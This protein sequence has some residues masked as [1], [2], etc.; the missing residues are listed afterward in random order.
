[1]AA[2]VTAKLALDTRGFNAGLKRAR[3]S[4]NSIGKAGAAAGLVAVAAGFTAVAI[5]MKK[6]IDLGGQLSDLADQTGVAAGDLYLL[7]TA[8][9][10]NGIEASKAAQKL[11]KMQK[12]IVEGKQGLSTYVRAF[13][14]MG[15]SI[16]S[17]DGRDAMEQFKEIGAA[18]NA[19][20]SAT[21]RAAVALQVFGGRTAELL[22]LFANPVAMEKAAETLGG[23]VELLNKN[24]KEFDR[25]SDILGQVG[26]KLDGFFV[27]MA[28]KVVT[29]LMP[30]LESLD[31]L[32]LS[33][34]GEAFGEGIVKG[35]NFFTSGAWLPSM[36]TAILQNINKLI[37]DVINTIFQVWNGFSA[38]LRSSFASWADIFLTRIKEMTKASF[39]AGLKNIMINI[40]ISFQINMM[41]ALQKIAAWW[42]NNAAVAIGGGGD[43]AG[44]FDKHIKRMEGLMLPEDESMSGAKSTLSPDRFV[45]DINTGI[46]KAKR[47]FFAGAQSPFMEFFAQQQKDFDYLLENVA[48]P[49]RSNRPKSLGSGF[50]VPPVG[51]N[52]PSTAVEV[53]KA[54]VIA[55]SLQRLGGGGAFA[56]FSDTANP[57]AQAVQEQKLTN[58]LLLRTNA[59]LSGGQSGRDVGTIL[60]Y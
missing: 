30:A 10:Q 17:L 20:P 4:L 6:A 14:M 2:K 51:E 1:M 9:E 35:I 54:G 28:S 13:D 38:M 18:I 49:P 27:G 55:Q 60:A 34:K 48:V 46:E 21:E 7:Q 36:F 8:F 26:K 41:K 33:Q 15:V 31:K 53:G 22:T 56:R 37:G 25:A 50:S 32:D 11:N 3:A 39:W 58:K 5:G 23:Q 40:A 57:A 45:A 59:L 42:D 29:E 16:E 47:S 12:A 52:L 19:M 24:A 43:T 44:S